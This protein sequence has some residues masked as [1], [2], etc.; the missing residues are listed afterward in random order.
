MSKLRVGI[1]V[2]DNAEYVI[3]AGPFEVFSRARTIGGVESR[4]SDDSA[5]FDVFTIG[6]TDPPC[7]RDGWA[8]DRAA[9]PV[10]NGAYDGA[11]RSAWRGWR[12]N[13]A[14]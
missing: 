6:R 11:T 13:A 10:D 8:S 2:F 3:F 12:A 9:V 5:P 1:Y 7:C 4:H 14:R